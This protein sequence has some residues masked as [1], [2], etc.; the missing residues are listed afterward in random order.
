MK[1]LAGWSLLAF[2]GVVPGP[3]S[4]DRSGADPAVAPSGAPDYARLS[5]WA[6]HPKTRDEADRV[7]AG[8]VDR[9]DV[10]AA[11]VFFVHPTTFL[12][13]RP[14]NADLGDRALDR[15]T[16]R[17]TIRSQASLF[18]G[19]G[20]VYAPR[21]R[22]ASLYS[23]TQ[24]DAASLAARELAFEDV[25]AAFDHFLATW[26]E[27]RPIVVA[28]H[29]QGS[30]HALRLLEERFAGRP[31]RKRLVAAYLA[32]LA[33]PTD[34]LART[35]PGLRRCRS[36]FDQ[37]CLTSWNTIAADADRSRFGTV[38]L[39]YPEGWE[40]SSGKKLV[41]T[42]PLSFARGP[43]EANGPAR[44]VRASGRRLRRHAGPTH[45]DCQRGLLVIE[46]P[47]GDVFGSNDGDYHLWDYGLFYLDVREAVGLRVDAAT[48]SS[49]SRRRR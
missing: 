16:D 26:N 8:E 25:L 46:P 7:P 18:N 38:I 3:A 36:L 17:T 49:A 19:A 48:G 42:N 27:G 32:G 1:R 22:Q 9:Q 15:R 29:S 5:S 43:A 12:A 35:L 31:L 4:A 2:F 28:G 6:A 14:A 10:A 24:R 44:A 20:R 13:L 39:H 23:V 21:Y 47:P 37:R 33:V 40:E 11:D 41:C 34:K 30:Q 45:A